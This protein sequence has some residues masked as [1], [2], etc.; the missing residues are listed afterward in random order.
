MFHDF[1]SLIISLLY[2]LLLQL[3]TQRIA[4]QPSILYK[5][6]SIFS[7]FLLKPIPAWYYSQSWLLLPLLYGCSKLVASYSSLDRKHEMDLWFILLTSPFPCPAINI[8]R[9]EFFICLSLLSQWW[10]RDYHRSSRSGLQAG[11]SFWLAAL[12][13]M[14][15]SLQNT[16]VSLCTAARKQS[17]WRFFTHHTQKLLF[18]IPYLGVTT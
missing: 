2:K 11:N 10:G 6:L 3:F 15:S 14:Y 16:C 4:P 18:H 8:T 1:S 13:N 17:H 9:T 7:P 5:K 12:S